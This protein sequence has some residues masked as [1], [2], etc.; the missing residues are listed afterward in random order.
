MFGWRSRIGFISPG[1]SGIHT[2]AIEMEMA[3]PEGVIF[4]STFL[5]GPK[6]LS[7]EHCREL[8]PQIGP[9]AETLAK[10]SDLDLIVMGGAPVCL[11]NGPSK[12]VEV[13]EGAANVRATTV[14]DGLVNALRRLDIQK[15]VVLTPY[16]GPEMVG[17]VRDFIVGA[18]FDIVAMVTGELEFGKHKDRSQFQ[19]YRMAKRAFLDAPAADG[20]LIVGGGTPFH[21]VIQTLE[22]DIGKPVVAN[23]FASLWNALTLANVREP[24]HGYGRLLT[25]F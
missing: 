7:V 10:K 13:I 16:Y 17:L 14:A 23:N 12:L 25:L 15:V 1:T 21:S 6:S 4:L 24:I 5:N 20:L 3:A 11:A 19:N 22:T 9:A 18:G 2:S 8:L